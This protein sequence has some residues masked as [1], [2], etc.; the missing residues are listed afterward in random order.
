MTCP[1]IPPSACISTINSVMIW[2]QK[3]AEKNKCLS[4]V[5]DKRYA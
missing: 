4:E 5:R 1:I 2:L 3:Y